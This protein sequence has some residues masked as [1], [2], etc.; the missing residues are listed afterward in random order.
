MVAA[1]QTNTPLLLAAVN[2]NRTPPSLLSTP[3]KHPFMRWVVVEFG[4]GDDGGS[5]G[6]VG[7]SV[8]VVTAVVSWTVVWARG[9]E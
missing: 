2:S 9:G 8:E 7:C 6:V 5:S 1:D 4:R 3:N